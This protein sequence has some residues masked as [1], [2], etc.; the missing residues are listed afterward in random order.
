[1][2]LVIA[3]DAETVQGE[4]V[5]KPWEINIDV[6]PYPQ[7]IGSDVMR[8]IWNVVFCCHCFSLVLAFLNQVSGGFGQNDAILQSP[9]PM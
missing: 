1:M 6:Q 4:R 2:N 5:L 7:P 9:I 8:L 3:A